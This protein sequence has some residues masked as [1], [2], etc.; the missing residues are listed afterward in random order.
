GYTVIDAVDGEEGLARF[1]ERMDEISLAIIDVIMPRKNG[2]ELFADIKRLKPDMKVIFTS[3][4]T[5]DVFPDGFAG[6]EEMLFLSKP[7]IPGELLKF[8]R[9]VLDE[10]KRGALRRPHNARE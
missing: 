6:G 1:T 4:Y 5:A 7:I 2:R 10:G 9:K 3:G 8:M